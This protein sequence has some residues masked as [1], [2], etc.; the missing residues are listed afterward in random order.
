MIY[1]YISTFIFLFSIIL[2]LFDYIKLRKY[3][4]KAL[5]LKEFYIKRKEEIEQKLEEYTKKALD[6]KELYYSKLNENNLKEKKL[7]DY[8]KKAL[9]LKEL[10]L[11][12][13][14][15]EETLIGKKASEMLFAT[16]QPV[17]NVLNFLEEVINTEIKTYHLIKIE[18]DSQYTADKNKVFSQKDLD[19][20][21]LEIYATTFG[22]FSEKYKELL[23]VFIDK[24]KL[25]EFVMSLIYKRLIIVLSVKNKT[26]LDKIITGSKLKKVLDFNKKNPLTK[27]SSPFLPSNAKIKSKFRQVNK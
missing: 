2:F 26:Q 7:E 13:I 9:D 6:L 10:Y 19:S 23:G 24:E 4:K 1:Y 12:K 3:T 18:I 25:P 22:V 17:S 21:C 14:K 20:M 15:E 27:E 5:E 11:K 16:D 8:T